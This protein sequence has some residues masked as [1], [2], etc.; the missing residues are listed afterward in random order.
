M[1]AEEYSESTKAILVVVDLQRRIAEL[2]ANILEAMQAFSFDGVG[3]ELEAAE[4]AL[5]RMCHEGRAAMDREVELEAQ[6]AYSN[7]EVEKFV[8]VTSR[9]KAELAD[10]QPWVEFGK[11]VLNE[12]WYLE[13]GVYGCCYGNR[14]KGH[15][16]DC[17]IPDMLARL[18]A[19]NA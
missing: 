15:D 18:E 9:L 6:L 4:I 12:R 8:A 11:R 2:E 7:S 10:V 1:D 16:P 13:D 5:V 19:D 14:K 3:D 17:P